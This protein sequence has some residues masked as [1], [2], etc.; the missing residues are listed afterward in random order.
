MANVIK[1]PRK[2]NGIDSDN[3]KCTCLWIQNEVVMLIMILNVHSLNYN[4]LSLN[5]A[6]KNMKRDKVTTPIRV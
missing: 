2:S 4:E 1:I 5:E 3:A 6:M